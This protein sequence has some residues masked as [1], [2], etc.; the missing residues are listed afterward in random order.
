MRIRGAKKS[1]ATIGLVFAIVLVSFALGLA[2]EGAPLQSAYSVELH[3]GV[4]DDGSCLG[5]YASRLG[6]APKP[7]DSSG[8]SIRSWPQAVLPPALFA[9][10]NP[11]LTLAVS[12][13]KIS[14]YL[15]DSVLLV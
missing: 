14:L 13:R 4:P 11:L 7:S 8:S 3:A 15:L 5:D 12:G 10:R 9:V 6:L 1:A 2:Q